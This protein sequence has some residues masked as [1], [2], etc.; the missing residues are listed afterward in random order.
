MSKEEL[1]NSE[2][3]RNQDISLLVINLIELFDHVTIKKLNFCTVLLDQYILYEKDSIAI[4]LAIQLRN[5]VTLL[6]QD[7]IEPSERELNI[8]QAEEVA[9]YLCVHIINYDTAAMTIIRDQKNIKKIQQ[10]A[11]SSELAR[12]ILDDTN[13]YTEDVADM[14]KSQRIMYSVDDAMRGHQ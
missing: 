5:D 8:V 13:F 4:Q 12:L 14:Q 11:T 1:I 2:Q 10:Y 3:R 9:I 6:L 7:T